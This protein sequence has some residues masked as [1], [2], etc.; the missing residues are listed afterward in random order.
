MA[1]DP[2]TFQILKQL[3]KRN[4]FLTPE[5]DNSV[6]FILV[7]SRVL[8]INNHLKLKKNSSAAGSTRKKQVFEFE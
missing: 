8:K 6:Y 4:S 7:I 3:I 1:R 5:S 2:D